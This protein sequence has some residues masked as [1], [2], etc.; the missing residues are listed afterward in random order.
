M[1]LLLDRSGAAATPAIREW[2]DF[3]WSAFCAEPDL[4]SAEVSRNLARLLAKWDVGA[5]GRQNSESQAVQGLLGLLGIDNAAH[6]TSPPHGRIGL[7]AATAGA[8]R[9]AA[10]RCAAGHRPQRRGRRRQRPARTDDRHDRIGQ[11]QTAHRPGLRSADA[12][13]PD[14]VQ[15]FLG[16]FKDEAGMDAFAGYPH[17]VA[18]VSN[19]EEKKSLVE[20]FGE[21]L[22]GILDARG[23]HFKETGNA[24]MGAAFEKLSE[25]NEA[26]L[27][28]PNCRR[29][30]RCS[31]SSTSSP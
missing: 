19:M 14:V 9:T 1:T 13:F 10:R 21:T 20:R 4:M 23:R 3:R 27:T 2:R 22:Y 6:L 31:S 7:R 5:T 24:I 11:V 28:H 18:V 16:D 12:P 26:R 15:V 25:Y 30:Q 17:T 29:C 8:G